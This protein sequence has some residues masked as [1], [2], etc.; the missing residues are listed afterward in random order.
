MFRLVDLFRQFPL[1]QI[2]TGGGPGTVTTVLNYYVYQTTFLF[3]GFGYGAALAILLVILMI[4]PVAAS[5][6]FARRVTL[7]RAV[8]G[9]P[10]HAAGHA[11][12]GTGR[13]LRD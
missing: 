4:I 7:D 10:G 9:P 1:F 2:M 3:G 6:W 8:T 11:H 13:F 12:A 5:F